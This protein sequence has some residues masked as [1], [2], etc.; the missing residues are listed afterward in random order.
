VACPPAVKKQP[1]PPTLG[2]SHL[3]FWKSLPTESLPSGYV[4]VVQAEG[5]EPIKVGRAIDVHK[6]L[7]GLQTGNPRPLKLLYVFPD[8]GELEWQLHRRLKKARMLGE[9]FSGEAVEEFLPFAEE[10]AWEMV[11]GCERSGRTKIPDYRKIGSGWFRKGKQGSVVTVHHDKAKVETTTA[12]RLSSANK[13]LPR[14]AINDRDLRY[15][16]RAE[17]TPA[18]TPHR[19]S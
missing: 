3:R 17:E 7:S 8:D 12:G 4:Y 19:P 1:Q 14:Y 16:R 10:L 15:K 13:D 2:E 5:D 6:R 18:F 11:K 9:W